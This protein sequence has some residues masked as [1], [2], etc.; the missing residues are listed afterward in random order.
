[1]KPKK[2]PKKPVSKKVQSLLDSLRRRRGERDLAK[3]ILIVC[4]DNKSAPAYF[5][6]MKVHLGLSATSLRVVGSGG[7]TQPIQVVDRAIELKRSSARTSSGTVP[8]DEVWCAIDGDYGTKIANARSRAN[9]NGVRIAVTTKCFEHWIVLHFAEYEKP[10]PDCDHVVRQL[11]RDFIPNYEKGRCDFASILSQVHD[12][13]RRAK[14]GRAGGIAR[15]E[16]PE[17]QNPCSELYL[18]VESIVR[19]QTNEVPEAP[20]TRK[21]NR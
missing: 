17:N 4:E 14:K 12:A 5:A 16:L 2:N 11:R 8:F 20:P 7:D 9:A 6:A 15:N 19:S 21:K 1:M 18:L 13:A 3:R 10:S